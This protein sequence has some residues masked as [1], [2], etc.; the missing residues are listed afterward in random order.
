MS[1]PVQIWLDDQ[2]DDPHRWAPE[3]FLHVVNVE[4]AV[5]LLSAASCSHASLD[6]DLGDG[7]PGGD[8]FRLVL[9]M[10]ETGHWPTSGIRVHSANGAARRRMLAD[11]DRYGP[12]PPSAHPENRGDWTGVN[13][14][15]IPTVRPTA[16]SPGTTNS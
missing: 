15:S 7:A 2:I 5:A 10:A 16:W 4:D 11:I 3:G 12:Y 14:Q 8:G 9:W 13:V 1:A 6:H